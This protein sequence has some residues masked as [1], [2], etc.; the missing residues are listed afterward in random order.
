MKEIIV[1]RGHENVLS[2]HRTTIEITKEAE[3]TLAGDCIVGVGA[4]KGMLDLSEEFKERLKSEC[5][6]EIVFEC[7]GV[8]DVVHARGS[9]KLVLDHPSDMVIRKSDYICGRTLA[10]GADK[11]SIDLKRELVEK[12]KTGAE[13]KVTLL[14]K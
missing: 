7:G 9:P 1:C 10:V 4:D 8:K 14:V 13:L 11:A 5:E 3:L 6:V 12:L 2:T